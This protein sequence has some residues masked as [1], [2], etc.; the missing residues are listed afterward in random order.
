M[1]LAASLTFGIGPVVSPVM[2]AD[3]ERLPDLA[4]LAPFDFRINIHSSGAKRLRFSSVIVNL[5]PG[6]FQLYGY[7]ED[8]T[9]VIGDGLLVR[10]QVLQ[11]N[12]TFVDR[13]T[14]ATMFW[15][16]DGHNHF[17]AQGLTNLKLHNSEGKEV[18]RTRKVGFC[19][20]DSYRYGSTLPSVYNS[21]SHVCMPA[22]NGQVPMGISVKWGYIYKSTIAYQWIDITGLPNGVYRVEVVAVPPFATG[23]RFVEGNEANNRGWTRIRITGTTVTVISRSARP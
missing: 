20:L 16:G 6:P 17:H 11:A 19:F 13:D 7:D 10:Q 18:A 22:P 8:G 9:A 14:T 21:A 5:G 23:G 2:A 4:V 12:G 15:S 3:G 1:L